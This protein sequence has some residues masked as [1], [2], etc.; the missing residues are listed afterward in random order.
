MRHEQT[1]FAEN[2]W[3]V[4]ST[5]DSIDTD[6]RR[7]TLFVRREVIRVCVVLASCDCEC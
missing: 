2:V 4:S 1:G 7:A 5:L 3:L 6:L